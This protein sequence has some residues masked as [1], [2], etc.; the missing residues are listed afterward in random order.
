MRGVPA[1]R[2]TAPPSCIGPGERAVREGGDPAVGR[3]PSPALEGAAESNGPRSSGTGRPRRTR[4]AEGGQRSHPTWSHRAEPAAHKYRPPQPSA[5]TWSGPPGDIAD[6][7]GPGAA[8]AV[9]V[10]AA[11]AGVIA[12]AAGA[13]DWSAGSLGTAVTCLSDYA[14]AALQLKP[15]GQ[16]ACD[17]CAR[18]PSGGIVMVFGGNSPSRRARSRAWAGWSGPLIRCICRRPE[19]SRTRR[20]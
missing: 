1:E 8:V 15:T 9:A 19:A 13:I 20:T 2:S 11:P 18:G 14:R 5:S 10:E 12:M 6:G 7:P 16:A 17:A 3:W 4:T